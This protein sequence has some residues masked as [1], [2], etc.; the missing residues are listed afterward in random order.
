[1]QF[2]WMSP[3]SLKALEVVHSP[4]NVF[5]IDSVASNMKVEGFFITSEGG[6]GCFSL[7]EES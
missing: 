6:E 4:N 3:L 7:N 5:Y 2:N 1:V